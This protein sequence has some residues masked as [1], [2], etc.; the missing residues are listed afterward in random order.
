MQEYDVIVVGSGLGGL[1]CASI[2][3]REGYSVCV[4]EKN[5]QFGG[6][7]QIYVRD[8]CIF[9]TGIHYIGGLSE[10][11]NTWQ[12]FKFLNLTDKL[13]MKQLDMDAFDK[14]SFDNDPVEYKYAQGYDR[15]METLTGYFPKEKKAIE[16]YCTTLQ[17]IVSQFPLY[18]VRE[19]EENLFLSPD[20]N[21]GTRSFIDSITA[22][23][24]LRSVLAG[25]NLLYAGVSDKTPLYV[26][27]LVLNSYI[28]SAWKMI[29]GGSQIARH[30]V[31]EIQ[32]DGG[33]V[34]NYKEVV[35][36]GFNNEKL[37]HVE[38][39]DGEK[40]FAK[41]F[42]SN[43]HP[44]QTIRLIE[45]DK[46]KKSYRN[47]INGLENTIGIFILNLV[48][49]KDTFPYLNFNHYHFR[50][51][52]V[53]DILDSTEDEWPESYALFT[54]A[55]SRSEV[56][57]ECVS[58]MTYMKFDWV[59]KWEAS[60]NMIPREQQ[61]RG[62]DYDEFKARMSEKLLAEVEKKFPGIRPKIKSMNASTPLSF[63]DYLG[64]GDG[65]LYGVLKDYHE[66]MRT[67]ISP[68]TKI[69]NLFLTG[70]NLNM[71]GVLGVTIGAVKTCAEF[72]GMSYLLKKIK[73]A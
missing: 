29:D 35:Q 44:K 41:N 48:L 30:L 16:T 60:K 64:N 51:N 55:T 31:K 40:F 22:D 33:T 57:T 28:E 68:R 4:L 71:H 50:R 47:R 69:P 2:L 25:N 49:Q 70:Q 12:F 32:N 7:L 61:H 9:D 65:S 67:F 6:N 72:L 37:T 45:Q 5:R 20:L 3:A 42:I 27:A 26:H 1:Q 34:L 14:I 15:F 36:F 18:R 66:P 21:I 46:L 53:W 62:D 11:Q 13:K 63:R 73:Q 59:K 52:E 38:T 10:G 8:K 58:V 24:K 17:N 39:A 56:F 43:V 54:P 19:G 23:Q